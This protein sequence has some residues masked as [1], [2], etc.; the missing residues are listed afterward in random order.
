MV[1]GHLKGINTVKKRLADG[2]IATYYYHRD[3]G[4]RLN[5]KPLSPEFLA[6]NIG[7]VRG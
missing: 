1:R 2:T 4:M 6:E 7:R 3:T 5:G